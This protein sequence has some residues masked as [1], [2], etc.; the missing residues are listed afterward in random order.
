MI[1]SGVM[2]LP[3]LSVWFPGLV[4]LT[5]LVMVQVNVTLPL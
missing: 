2:A 5:T 1:C 3:V 4:T